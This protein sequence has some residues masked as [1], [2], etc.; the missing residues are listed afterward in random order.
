M[1]RTLI[2]TLA[3]GGIVAAGAGPLRAADAPQHSA[4]DSL[5][6]ALSQIIGPTSNDATVSPDK[7]VPTLLM[8]LPGIPIPSTGLD[9]TNES[10]MVF[11][12]QTLDTIPGNTPY[13]SASHNKYSDLYGDIVANST[14]TP[15][16]YG[17]GD[18]QTMKGL[19]AQL[20]PDGDTMKAYRKYQKAF[21][22]AS[23]D[24]N[25]YTLA[26]LL[27]QKDP[28]Q[29]AIP[30]NPR[31]D[32]KDNPF[33]SGHAAA[34]TALITAKDNWDTATTGNRTT[35][36]GLLTQYRSL[37]NRGAASWWQGLQDA[38]TV[39]NSDQNTPK[40]VTFPKPENWGDQCTWTNF[41]WKSSSKLTTSD[42]ANK[43]VEAAASFSSGGL[44]I[45][46]D[47]GWDKTTQ[48]AMAN[49]TDT[50]VSVELARVLVYRPWLD[51]SVFYSNAWTYNGSKFTTVNG[52]SDGAPLATNKGL[53]PV[54][55]DQ[56]WLA[57][58]LKITG[59]WIKQN[60]SAMNQKIHASLSV[61]YGPF[62]VSG[63]YSQ[64]DKSTFASM[65]NDQQSILAPG[66]QAIAFVCSTIPASPLRTPVPAPT[67][68]D[69]KGDGKAPVSKP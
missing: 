21:N 26:G 59:S 11:L 55:V 13:W 8:L 46:A 32:D 28:S 65:S 15:G 3:L 38:M 39:Q 12:N 64:E 40:C 43:N 37:A 14:P 30:V 33:P 54:M 60:A 45:S 67:D 35:V 44:S 2:S 41:S 69:G 27:H 10:D 31:P 16:K 62:S 68:D 20:D 36:A 24:Y 22:Q 66:I 17:D 5:F 9:T 56:V 34:K 51:A 6:A 1:K 47:G 25:V 50:E 49:S 53:M 58:N 63:S 19:Q 7:K 29:P 4:T 42:F 18:L 23:D 57:R 52:L 48:N 61:S